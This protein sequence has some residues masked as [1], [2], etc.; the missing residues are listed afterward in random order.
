MGT[1]CAQSDH[2]SFDILHSMIRK[3]AGRQKSYFTSPIVWTKFTN[4]LNDLS[5]SYLAANSYRKKRW[6][7]EKESNPNTATHHQS[8]TNKLVSRLVTRGC[9]INLDLSQVLASVVVL[10]TSSLSCSAGLTPAHNRTWPPSSCSGSVVDVADTG[11]NR[12]DSEVCSWSSDPRAF[13]HNILQTSPAN[14]WK[15]ASDSSLMLGWTS[16]PLGTSA[17]WFVFDTA[18]LI[19]LGHQFSD[20]VMLSFK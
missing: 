9:G 12:P 7:G 2:K 20:G 5:T 10:D 19:E 14:L 1:G 15:T 3:G 8:V 11:A 17:L 16:H 18:S 4:R 6:D 13:C